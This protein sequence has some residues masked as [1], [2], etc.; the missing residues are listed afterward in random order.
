MQKGLARTIPVVGVWVAKG[1]CGPTQSVRDFGISA[2]LISSLTH[3]SQHKLYS[4]FQLT[5]QEQPGYF[6]LGDARGGGLGERLREDTSYPPPTS[7]SLLS[8]KKLPDRL[9]ILSAG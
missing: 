1:K 4:L 3:F 5:S 6:S 7:W 9:P 2:E 8:N